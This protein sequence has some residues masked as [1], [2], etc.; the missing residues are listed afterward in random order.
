MAHEG[1]PNPPLSVLSG[2]AARHLSTKACILLRELNNAAPVPLRADIYLRD[3][4]TVPALHDGVET[5][6]RFYNNK[7]PHESRGPVTPVEVHYAHEESIPRCGHPPYFP[8]FVVLIMG[9]TT[10][11]CKPLLFQNAILKQSSVSFQVGPATKPV[12][13]R[14]FGST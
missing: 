5:Y 7:Q 8:S 4:E 9:L 3:Q 11:F 13:K 10:C 2:A 14:R 1:A 12:G 6:F